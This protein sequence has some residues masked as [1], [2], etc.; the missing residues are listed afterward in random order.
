MAS[1]RPWPGRGLCWL[2]GRRVEGVREMCSG[3]NFIKTLELNELVNHIAQLGCCPALDWAPQLNSLSPAPLS[4]SPLALPCLSVF[5]YFF[6]SAAWKT[7]FVS[8]S[9][10]SVEMNFRLGAKGR[11][12]A[13]AKRPWQRQQIKW[14]PCARAS[15]SSSSSW[16]LKKGSIKISV[17][18]RKGLNDRKLC[19][20]TQKPK[21]PMP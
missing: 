2:K 18:R 11:G 8:K 16:P 7:I 5:I 1:P 21:F 3:T 6:F 19:P 13:R 20:K 12:E 17:Q 9:V 4:A 14:N 10:M 15:S